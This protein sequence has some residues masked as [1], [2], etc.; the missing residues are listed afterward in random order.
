M[1]LEGKLAFQRK[2]GPLQLVSVLIPAPRCSIV[3]LVAEQG[4][5]GQ[6]C[7]PHRIT[8]PRQR[9]DRRTLCVRRQSHQTGGDRT[10][11][12]ERDLTLFS[13]EE[14]VTCDFSRKL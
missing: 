4:H 12:C 9:L 8:Q 7:P 14:T 1:A 5:A 2:A 6:F 10:D 13:T 3:I 11:H